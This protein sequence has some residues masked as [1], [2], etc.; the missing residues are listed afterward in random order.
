MMQWIN[1]FRRFLL[2]LFFITLFSFLMFNKVKIRPGKELPY[3]EITIF[4]YTS[5]SITIIILIITISLVIY[6]NPKKI[7][8]YNHYLNLREWFDKYFDLLLTYLDR[9]WINFEAIFDMLRRSPYKNKLFFIEGNYIIRALVLIIF[10]I[11][12]FY[13]NKLSYFYKILPL[14]V[15]RYYFGFFSIYKNVIL[16]LHVI[17]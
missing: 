9:H 1:I 8:I 10:P 17:Q 12:I 13:C 16:K 7:V 6:K 5:F 14:L 2:I 4:F 15:Y 3:T 11:D